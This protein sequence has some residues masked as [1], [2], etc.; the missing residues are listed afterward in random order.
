MS[1]SEAT[2]SDAAVSENRLIAGSERPEDAQERAMRPKR[3]ADYRGQPAVTEQ[4]GL[5]IEAALLAVIE[6]F[7]G[8]PVGVDNLGAAL[9]EE[10]GTLEEVVEPYLIQQG[11]IMRT[12]RG[13]VATSHAYRHFGLVN[14]DEPTTAGTDGTA[15]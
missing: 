2:L 5:F 12:P 6:K 15:V 8:G 7:S 11:L 9:S 4:L 10:T 13:R 1:A 14:P 3:L